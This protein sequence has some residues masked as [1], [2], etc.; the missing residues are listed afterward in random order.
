MLFPLQEQAMH[1]SWDDLTF[2]QKQKYLQEAKKILEEG[3]VHYESL[4]E[5]AQEIYKRNPMELLQE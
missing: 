4:E 2:N 1:V 5:A 3:V